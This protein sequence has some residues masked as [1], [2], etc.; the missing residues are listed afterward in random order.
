MR[1]VSLSNRYIE[2]LGVSP[3]LQPKKH[4][5]LRKADAREKSNY[6]HYSCKGNPNKSNKVSD[7]SVS[8]ALQNRTFSPT[9]KKQDAPATSSSIANCHRGEYRW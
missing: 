2:I 9:I 4:D 6:G 7:L 1:I 3:Q 8:F 5:T